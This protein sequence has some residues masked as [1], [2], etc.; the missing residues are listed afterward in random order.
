MAA[1]LTVTLFSDKPVNEA[2]PILTKL[3]PHR[4]Y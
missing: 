1:Y 3:A 4:T 2:F